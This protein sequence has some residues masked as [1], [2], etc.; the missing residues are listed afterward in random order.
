MEPVKSNAMRNAWLWLIGLPVAYVATALVGYSLG[1]VL[2]FSEGEI[3]SAGWAALMLLIGVVLFGI[4]TYFA[5][6]NG[7]AAQS[8]GSKRPF[9][10][11][12]IALFVVVWF[13]LTG[14]LSF[15]FA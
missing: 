10:P 15:L 9:L 4:P 7:R 14:L 11:A 12:L 6:S 8:A 13:V 2:G 3:F 5:Y 1:A